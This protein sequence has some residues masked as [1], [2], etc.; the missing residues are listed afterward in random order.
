MQA[1]FLAAIF[2]NGGKPVH[3]DALSL[4]DGHFQGREELRPLYDT[5][6]GMVA[7]CFP[8][9]E[10][11]PTKGYISF[12]NPREFALAKITRK[13]IRVGLD[14][15]GRELAG[16]VGK[17]KSLG[18]MARISHMVEIAETQEIDGELANLLEEANGRVNS[19]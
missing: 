7:R 13:A 6:A 15:G 17:A 18:A 5:L 19:K 8:D 2:R 1:N 10:V 4:L 12:R 14:L 3:G 16:R 9:A 11:V